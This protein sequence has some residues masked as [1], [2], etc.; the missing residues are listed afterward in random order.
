MLQGSGNAIQRIVQTILAAQN[1]AASQQQRLD[2]SQLSVQVPACAGLYRGGC[3]ENATE[4]T[5][6]RIS[7]TCAVQIKQGD[8]REAASLASTLLTTG[9]P[10]EVLHFGFQLLQAVVGQQQ[11]RILHANADGYDHRRTDPAECGLHCRCVS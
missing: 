9:Q 11:P 6:C 7:L 5:K 4:S 2:A 1:P 10:L 3:P 8:P